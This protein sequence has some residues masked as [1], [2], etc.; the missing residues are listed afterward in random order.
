MWPFQSLRDQQK[1]SF[2]ITLL[3]R[4]AMKLE[5]HC[6]SRHRANG[7]KGRM[8]LLKALPTKPLCYLTGLGGMAYAKFSYKQEGREGTI[9]SKKAVPLPFIH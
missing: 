1:D 2:K 4:K 9:P 5:W 3:Q 7:D 6:F 8:V